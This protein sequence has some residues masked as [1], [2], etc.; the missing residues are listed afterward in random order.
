MCHCG[1]YRPFRAP[2]LPAMEFHRRTFRDRIG[3]LWRSKVPVFITSFHVPNT[4]KCPIHHILCEFRRLM[5][6]NRRIMCTFVPANSRRA[7]FARSRS[8]CKEGALH[9]EMRRG[10]LFLQYEITTKEYR[11]KNIAEVDA[12]GR[13]IQSRMVCRRFHAVTRTFM[14]RIVY[15]N[16]VDITL[17]RFLL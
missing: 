13:Y 12:T 15:T 1:L 16:G 6:G 14:G 17:S 3:Q 8:G 10:R 2:D 5:N 7:G 9:F 11:V 4:K